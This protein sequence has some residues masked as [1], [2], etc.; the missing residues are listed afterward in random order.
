M[1]INVLKQS[2]SDTERMLAELKE[3]LEQ[4]ERTE[5]VFILAEQLHDMLCTR[6][7]EEDCGWYYEIHNKKHNWD[8]NTHSRWITKAQRLQNK[9][10]ELNTSV[11]TVI[12]SFYLVTGV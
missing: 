3:E 1:N 8:G 12:E 10:V 6:N 2:I 9:C 11:D 4:A 7:H 5:P